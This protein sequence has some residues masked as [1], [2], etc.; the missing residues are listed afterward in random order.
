[1]FRNFTL[2]LIVG[3][4]FLSLCRIRAQWVYYHAPLSVLSKFG[5]IELPQLLNSIGLLPVFPPETQEDDKPPIDLT[6]IKH[7][8]LVLCLGKEWHRFTGHYL[9]PTGIRVEFIK[10]DFRGQ[11]PRHFNEAANSNAFNA[12]WWPR[13]ETS[14]VPAD[15]N[16]LNKEDASRYVCNFRL[17]AY[18]AFNVASDTG[19]TRNL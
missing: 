12:S 18:I 13:P 10:S 16:D 8:N 1:M 11:L 5:G 6:P 14:Y 17:Y 3:A 9:V 15:V 7:F 19:P 4:A 2:S